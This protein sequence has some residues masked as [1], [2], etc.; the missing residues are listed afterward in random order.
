MNKLSYKIAASVLKAVKLCIALG[1]GTV[2]DVRGL[3]HK[4]ELV[5]TEKKFVQNYT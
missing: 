5:F 2:V 4:R 3:L 1:S